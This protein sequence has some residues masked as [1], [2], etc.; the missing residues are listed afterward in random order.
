LFCTSCGREL[1]SGEK[2]CPG[3]GLA[4]GGG[5]DKSSP[6][7]APQPSGLVRWGSVEVA[8][9]VLALVLGAVVVVLASKVVG[10]WTG[11]YR[12]ATTAWVSSTLLGLVI[13]PLVWA[14][15]PRS[16][17]SLPQ[18]LGLARPAMGWPKAIGL[19]A[20]VLAL[21]LGSTALYAKSVE[22]LGWKQFA[23]PDIPSNLLFP[24]A[25][26]TLTFLAIA[27]WTPFTEEMFFRG[28]VLPGLLGRWGPALAV[29]VSALV[30]GLF[31]LVPALLV[32]VF[33][34]GLLLGWLRHRT[35]SVW[36]CILAHAGQNA[37]A[38]I[39]T[40]LGV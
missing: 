35:A 26:I 14:L 40:R 28:F 1:A 33:V 3:C 38:L 36:P 31:H 22:W 11:E 21:S 10:D 6:P 20:G 9:G 15:G 4:A 12:T 24:G 29:T 5:Q 27:L 17:K 23:P 30:F 34:T 2:F 18:A 37:I 13:L 19:A 8:L 25:W 32:P 7:E 16:F 39:A